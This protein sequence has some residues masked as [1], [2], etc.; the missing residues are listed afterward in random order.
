LD[1]RDLAPS[2]QAAFAAAAAERLLPAYVRYC[3]ETGFDGTLRLRTALQYVWRHVEAPSTDQGKLRQQHDIAH[4]LTAV[5]EEPASYFSIA[6]QDATAAVT[7]CLRFLLGDDEKGAVR[8]A[9]SGFDAAYQYAVFSSMTENVQIMTDTLMQKVLS[10]TLVQTEL[11]RQRRDLLELKSAE[12]QELAR[13]AAAV[14]A[15][16]ERET[17]I[18]TTPL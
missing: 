9:G 14:H 7:Y 5:S 15:R 16:A 17:A 13:V 10:H 1:L 12:P 18:S 4:A 8:A 11:T 2:G 3:K 6:A